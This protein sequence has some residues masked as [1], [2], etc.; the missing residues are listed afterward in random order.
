MGS[1][2][3]F[4]PTILFSKD[5]SLRD[6]L[7]V[8]VEESLRGVKST[9]DLSFTIRCTARACSSGPMVE[10]TM[11]VSSP[12]R[13]AAR[14]CISGR[15]AK[16]MTANS[17]K[18]TA[19]ALAF[20]TIPTERDSREHGGTGRSTE[21]ASTFGQQVRST[22]VFTWMGIRK[23]RG[24]LTILLCLSMNSNKATAAFKN[25]RRWLTRLKGRTEVINSFHIL[26]NLREFA[27]Q[28]IA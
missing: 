26:N 9:R 4:T 24:N 3:K 15:T 27:V 17:K 11:A 21:K 25:D 6:K 1:D 10:Y 7:T 14:A 19:L 13:R 8:G 20:F 23:I 5:F 28:S 16:S 22:T 18:I 2:S 12:A